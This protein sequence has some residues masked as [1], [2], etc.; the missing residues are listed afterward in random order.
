M[1]NVVLPSPIRNTP[2]NTRVRGP[3]EVHRC[4]HSVR[5]E[6]NHPLCTSLLRL[7]R[8]RYYPWG[9]SNAQGD[10]SAGK[11][12]PGTGGDHAAGGDSDENGLGE[13]HLFGSS[14][15]YI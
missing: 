12:S 1:H 4:G 11:E 15:A 6:D 9:S 10:S 3:T 7:H 13:F 5:W 8:C 2:K 14:P